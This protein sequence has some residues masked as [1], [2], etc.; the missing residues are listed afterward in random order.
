MGIVILTTPGDSKKK[1]TN[2]LHQITGEKVDLVIIQKVRKRPFLKR[3][4]KIYTENKLSIFLKE[5]WYSVVL[6]INFRYKKA[7]TYF[8]EQSKIK[9]LKDNYL[10]R[11]LEVNSINDSNVLRELKVISPDLMVI[12]GSGIIKPNVIN[13]AKRVI[14]L[15]MGICPYYRGALANQNALLHNDIRRIGATIH[16]AEKKVDTGDIITTINADHRKPPKEMFKELNDLAIKT[17]LEV[18]VKL[19]NGEE[20]PR[21]PQNKSR[22]KNLLLKDW[23]PS[24]RHRLAKLILEREKLLEKQQRISLKPSE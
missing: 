3:L 11:V 13:T 8:R 20:L 16:Y 23:T 9:D 6:R 1:F 10:P 12:W 2:S 17:Y 18:I 19:F 5:I 7:L 15:H 22:S 21:I 24:K 14:N 4:S